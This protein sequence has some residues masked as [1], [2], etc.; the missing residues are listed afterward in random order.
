MD[1]LDRMNAMIDYL[2][3]HLQ[4]ESGPLDL[5]EAA[6]RTGY[7]LAHIQRMFPIV[8]DIT[9]VSYTHLRRGRSGTGGNRLCIGRS[10]R[11][12][13]LSAL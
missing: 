12:G 2:E 11:I 10:G 7:S 6:K 8:A 13:L 3:K 5:T 1:W 4:V 9:S